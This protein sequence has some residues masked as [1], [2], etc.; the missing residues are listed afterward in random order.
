MNTGQK[1]LLRGLI[2]AGT[3]QPENDVYEAA[4]NKTCDV[5]SRSKSLRST[6]GKL[7]NR[8]VPDRH[9]N[10]DF[11]PGPSTS[12]KTRKR[13]GKGKYPLRGPTKRKVKEHRLK[14]VGL[15]SASSHAPVGAERESIMKAAWVRETA[16]AEEV[17]KK[18]KEALGWNSL[19][20]LQYMY[21]CGRY[22]RPAT[23]E[24]VE[25]ATCWDIT[26]VKALMGSGC[27]YVSRFAALESEVVKSNSDDHGC[28]NVC[29]T[30]SVDD[31][32][33]IFEDNNMDEDKVTRASFRRGSEL[34]NIRE[35]CLLAWSLD[36]DV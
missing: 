12:Q 25:N 14:I 20:D 19:W 31:S 4:S 13:D 33:V 22:L 23:L 21:S 6:L 18:I 27:L 17:A 32:S 1:C 2:R 36:C 7:F 28:S 15:K 30:S 29:N 35:E 34:K 24:D 16:S 10:E 26:T 8:R 5:V 11:E 3:N 9:E